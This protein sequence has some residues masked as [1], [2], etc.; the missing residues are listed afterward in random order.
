[1][2]GLDT[3]CKHNF[4]HYAIVGASSIM[5]AKWPFFQRKENDC[6][7]KKYLRDSYCAEKFLL[8]NAFSEDWHIQRGLITTFNVLLHRCII[9]LGC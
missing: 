8:P 4:G 2:I 5:P 3:L 6:D 1:M 7:K 9:S